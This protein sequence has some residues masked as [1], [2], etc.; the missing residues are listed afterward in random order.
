MS[1]SRVYVGGLPY[2]VREKDLER[3]FKGFGRTRDILLKNGYGFVEFEDSRDADDA[4]YEM[5]GKELMGRRIAVEQAKSTAR[6]SNRDRYDGGRRGGRY[7]ERGRNTRFGPPQ[8]TEYRLI[9][10]NLSSSVSWQDLKDYVRTA[11]EVTYCDAHK[12]RRNEGV[13]EFASSSDMRRA[14]EKLDDTELNGRRIR[15]IEDRRGGRSGGGRGR[16]RSHS[17]SVSRRRSRSKSARSSRSRSRSKS[18]SKSKSPV[19]SRSRS[20]SRT[21][22]SRE[23]SKSRSRSRSPKRLRKDASRER[24]K[25]PRQSRSKHG[26]R[27]PSKSRGSSRDRSRSRSPSKTRDDSRRRDRSKS[28]SVSKSRGDSRKRDRSRSRS[29]RSS[30]SRHDS[31][32]PSRGS[33][34]HSRDRS[35]SRSRSVSSRKG[36]ASRNRSESVDK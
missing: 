24:S 1:S 19:K 23:L 35:I 6:G 7:N 26:S 2:G 9:V 36:K 33:R 21:K 32:S 16:S 8:R 17:R 10:E 28:R 27:S 18:R 5:N 22:K 11:G 12:K 3:F 14:I 30:R 15:L 25:S 29:H 31:R 34:D 20:R 13:V 4:V